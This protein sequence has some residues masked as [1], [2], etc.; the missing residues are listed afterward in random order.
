M[1]NYN[2][3]E[4]Q[5][6]VVGMLFGAHLATHG[7]KPDPNCEFCKGFIISENTGQALMS[8]KFLILDVSDDTKINT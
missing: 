4:D 2:E 5:A 6:G 7:G 1:H 3:L 8:Y